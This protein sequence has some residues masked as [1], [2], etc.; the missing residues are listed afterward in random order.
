MPVKK[1]APVG[2]Y[3]VYVQFV[4][5]KDGKVVDIKPLTSLG[6]GM[7]EEAVRVIRNSP[8]WIAAKQF[9][10]NVNAYRKQPISFQVTSR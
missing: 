8:R 1:K 7:E 5:N 6:Y 4:V 10:R 9:G 3:T 2:I